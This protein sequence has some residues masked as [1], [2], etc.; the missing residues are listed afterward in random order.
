MSINNRISIIFSTRKLDENYVKH[1]KYSCGL[2]E[3]DIIPIENNHQ[4]SLSEAY[5]MGLAKAKYDIIVYAHDD[6]CFVTDNWGRKLCKH[7]TRN[8][9]Y[10][11]IGV[12]GTDNLISGMWWE[13]RASMHGVVNHS[14]HGKTWT[15]HYSA[16]QGNKIKQM[17]VIDGVFFAIDKTKIIHRF[18]EEFKGYHFYDL[19]FGFS[20]HLA[21]VKLGVCTDIRVTHMSVGRTNDEWVANKKQFEELYKDSL[22]CSL[23]GLRQIQG[24]QP[25]PR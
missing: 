15:N 7:F 25:L 9:D 11:I 22:P 14:D 12:A 2:I 24:T 3:P 19:A 23:N 4:Y 5:N 10:G 13:D 20:N 1:L 16:D 18:N 8:P 6:I 21:G 17:V